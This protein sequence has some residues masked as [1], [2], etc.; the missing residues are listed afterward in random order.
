MVTK[1]YARTSA[2]NAYVRVEMSY[3]V[4][5]YFYPTQKYDTVQN[6]NIANTRTNKN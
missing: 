4:F 2:H 5:I 1:M 3:N 6:K